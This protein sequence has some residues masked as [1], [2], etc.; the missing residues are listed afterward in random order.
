MGFGS[1]LSAGAGMGH[2]G[3]DHNAA[4]LTGKRHLVR[5]NTIETSGSSGKKRRVTV[6]SSS[7]KRNE[8]SNSSNRHEE[9]IYD[10]HLLAN[11]G[12]QRLTSL[13]MNAGKRLSSIDRIG[14]FLGNLKQNGRVSSSWNGTF[15]SN[16]DARN[17]S[18][19]FFR[20]RL[21]KDDKVGNVIQTSYPEVGDATSPDLTYWCPQ[22]LYPNNS[23]I[24]SFQDSQQGYTLLNPALV[25]DWKGGA[26]V[27]KA[28]DKSS[29]LIAPAK[30]DKIKNAFYDHP[31]G[32]SAFAVVNRP[33]LEDMSWNLN[34]LKLKQQKFFD[35]SDAHDTKLGCPKFTGDLV[36]W[37]TTGDPEADPPTTTLPVVG[38]TYTPTGA[39]DFYGGNP[40]HCDVSSFHSDK[41]RR[42]SVIQQ[43]NFY[44][45]SVLSL[46]ATDVTSRN[47]L[48]AYAYMPV[49]RFGTLT[50]DFMNKN[51]TGATVEVILYK[52]KKSQHLSPYATDY[53]TPDNVEIFPVDGTT[54]A[55]TIK[56][57][58]PLSRIVSTIG[59]GYIDTVG[60][61]YATE[62]LQGRVPSVQDIYNNPSYPLLPKLKKTKESLMPFT[63]VMRNKFA[64][65]S[66]SRRQ[67]TI[68]LPGEMYDPCSI[69][70]V[71]N[72]DPV[73]DTEAGCDAFSYP[74]LK[75]SQIP[76]LDQYS[77]GVCIAVNGQK[78]TRFFDSNPRAYQAASTS[79]G[80]GSSGWRFFLKDSLGAFSIATVGETYFFNDSQWPVNNVSSTTVVGGGVTTETTTPL[81]PPFLQTG[82]VSSGILHTRPAKFSFALRGGAAPVPGFTVSSVLSL[83]SGLFPRLD[84]PGSGF[85]NG[86]GGPPVT[87]TYPITTAGGVPISVWSNV[88]GQ[89]TELH[90]FVQNLDDAEI[91][92]QS[93]T[94]LPMGD[95]HGSAHVDY[96]ASYTEHIGSCAYKESHERNLFCLGDP[97]PPVLDT[98]SASITLPKSQTSSR[99]I[100]PATAVVRT[101]AVNNTLLDSTGKPTGNPAVS[102]QTYTSGGISH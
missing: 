5:S 13:C 82:F 95:N 67:L 74:Q 62:N 47:G 2:S 24:S 48:S 80:S 78:M 91:P 90:L 97:V 63:E 8:I 40:W 6:R 21:S 23:A 64:L 73:P 29:Y 34:K 49:L 14:R 32:T 31:T 38:S 65:T 3:F 41:H 27:L 10:Q 94:E 59:K 37:A 75:S 52:V 99:M 79:L 1:E 18:I 66:G 85:V 46:S 81:G 60:D 100:L 61:T 76:I 30:G 55:T 68:K 58:Y 26:N 86:T 98:S 16:I 4:A 35:Y 45:S 56:C 44:N 11:Q 88:T 42:Q 53:S 87:G 12:P 15:H 36:T 96:C 7:E 25:P 17:V 20:H 77:Y 92:Y 22:I 102:D 54:P 72:G 70:I 89:Y 71:S 93:A 19:Q 57:T 9:T 50:Y 39:I 69:P 43:N 51:D 83:N 84:E 33:D 101:A 28:S